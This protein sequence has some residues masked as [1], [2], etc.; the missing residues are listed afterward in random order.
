[1]IAA[2]GLCLTTGLRAA[3]RSVKNVPD[4]LTLKRSRRLNNQGSTRPLK[5]DRRVIMYKT[6]PKWPFRNCSTLSTI[7]ACA[8]SYPHAYT[9]DFITIEAAIFIGLVP[10][11]PLPVRGPQPSANLTPDSRPPIS[12]FTTLGSPLVSPEFGRCLGSSDRR[13]RKGESPDWRWTRS[14]I[15]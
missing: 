13:Q 4:I 11:L 12:P 10:L 1:M 8:R 7:L 9:Q 2:F 14:W 15:A 3:V 5:A 6:C